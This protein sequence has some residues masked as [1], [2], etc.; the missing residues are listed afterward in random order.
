MSKDYDEPQ[1]PAGDR[2]ARRPKSERPRSPRP[3]GEGA[4]ASP[5]ADRSSRPPAARDAAARSDAR[6]GPR[7]RGD[8]PYRDRDFRPG[9]TGATDAGDG[10]RQPAADRPT[11]P[12][13]ASVRRRPPG[14]GAADS[15]DRGS[16][17]R[18]ASASDQRRRSA[19]YG[20]EP[21]R[22]GPGDGSVADRGRR[23]SEVAPGRARGAFKPSSRAPRLSQGEREPAVVGHEPRPLGEQ[24]QSRARHQRVYGLQAARAFANESPQR[25]LRAYYNPKVSSSFGDLSAQLSELKRPYRIV[26]DDELERI[27]EST[28][29]EGVV[30]VIEARPAQTLDH[31]LADLPEG[32]VAAFWLDGVENPHN[33]GAI[34][35]SADHFGFA[36]LLIA[37]AA[38]LASAAA[39]RTAMGALSRLNLVDPGPLVSAL[40]RL[41]AAAFEVV[42]TDPEGGSGLT[43]D[44]LA[45]RTVLVLGSESHGLSAA[46][47]RFGLPSL[48]IAGTGR[49]QSLNV[50]QSAAVLGYQWQQKRTA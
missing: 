30:L 1:P 16:T 24:M 48:T 2:P 18:P 20:A 3:A 47:R 37:D 41:K 4:K 32:P 13:G 25:V 29:H 36:A 5:W 44:A 15:V 50:A 34:A 46:W 45:A 23:R 19:P 28:H 49:V 22:F 31:W 38:D 9:R 42:L 39:H 11:S 27:A 33:I 26:G 10:E 7:T 40:E 14:D 12:Y 21:K 17:S 35:R 6:A 43:A 8:N